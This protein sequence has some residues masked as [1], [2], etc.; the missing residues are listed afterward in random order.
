MSRRKLGS[1]FSKGCITPEP[2]IVY[3]YMWSFLKWWVSPTNPWVFLVIYIISRLFH[4]FP[5]YFSPNFPTGHPNN[6]WP[7][8]GCFWTREKKSRSGTNPHSWGRI[9]NDLK[10]RNGKKLASWWFKVPF[11][12]WLSDPFT[13]LS[14]LQL[15]DERVTSN[16]L[17]GNTLIWISRPLIL[18]EPFFLACRKK[19]LQ[20]GKKKKNKK[21]LHKSSTTQKPFFPLD[22]TLISP[23]GHKWQCP[24]S[25]PWGDVKISAMWNG[26][27]GNQVGGPH[28]EFKFGLQKW[29]WT[30]HF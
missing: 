15:A 30:N 29:N 21:Q 28:L 11:L 10:G 17:D 25:W 14:D 23:S 7:R 12:G 9:R 4:P 16:H 3:I 5:N 18:E 13:W 24:H 8:C 1:R 26:D 20:F 22:L 2:P 27:Q 19:L 6:H